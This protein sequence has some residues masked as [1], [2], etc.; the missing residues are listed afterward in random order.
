MRLGEYF[1]KIVLI[2]TVLGLFYAGV[3]SVLGVQGAT[4]LDVGESSR[5]VIANTSPLGDNAAP[6]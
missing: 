3:T 5:A 6:L 1:K 4:V 2:M